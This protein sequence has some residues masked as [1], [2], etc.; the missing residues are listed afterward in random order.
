MSEKTANSRLTRINDESDSRV[1][2]LSLNARNEE[3]VDSHSL[4]NDGTD[5]KSPQHQYPILALLVVS[6][7]ALLC[8]GLF[9]G[10]MLLGTMYGWPSLHVVLLNNHMFADRCQAIEVHDSFK[11]NRS[12]KRMGHVTHRALL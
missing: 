4:L 5:S 10:E 11:S 12:W 7:L 1:R 8:S 6:V 9:L 2:S 3:L